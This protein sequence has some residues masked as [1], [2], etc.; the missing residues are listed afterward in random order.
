M[1]T[2]TATLVLSYM[3]VHTKVRCPGQTLEVRIA[4]G[5]GTNAY[6]KI[7]MTGTEDGLC[8]DR[9]AGILDGV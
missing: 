2:R 6:C 8:L 4:A 1:M 7:V 3:C 5:N 9:R